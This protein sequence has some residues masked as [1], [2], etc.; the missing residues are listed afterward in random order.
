MAGKHIT[1][2]S[3]IMTLVAD[4]IYP[5]GKTIEGYAED[6]LRTL[7]EITLTESHMGVDGKLSHGYVEYPVVLRLTLQPDQDGYTVFENIAQTQKVLRAPIHLSLT[8]IDV[9]LKR[10][11]TLTRG[12]LNAWKPMPDATRIMQ[13]VEAQMTFER[14][15]FE[16]YEG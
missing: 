5:S 13:P 6:S 1:A 11:Y 12:A 16:E 3:V 15:T 14:C 4:E 10:K 2:A 9:S 8:I 7:E